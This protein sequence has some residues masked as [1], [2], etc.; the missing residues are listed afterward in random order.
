[1][2]LKQISFSQSRE[3]VNEYGLKKWNKIGVEAELGEN[4]P[5]TA[6]MQHLVLQVE[7]WHNS[8]SQTENEIKGTEVTQVEESTVTK[9]QQVSGLIEIISMCQSIKA[10]EMRRLSVERDEKEYPGLRRAFDKRM[11]ELLTNK[12]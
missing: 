10:L 7:S 12:Q 3:T 1:M 6:A 4:E 5:V 8:L 2:I 9:E 11:S